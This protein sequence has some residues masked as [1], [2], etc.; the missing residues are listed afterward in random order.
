MRPLQKIFAEVFFYGSFLKLCCFS[1]DE[2]GI[3][4]VITLTLAII[5]EK[6]AANLIRRHKIANCHV[7]IGLWILTTNI[8]KTALDFNNKLYEIAFFILKA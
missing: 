3:D 5:F 2:K 4:F 7:K 8:T 1:R 6:R